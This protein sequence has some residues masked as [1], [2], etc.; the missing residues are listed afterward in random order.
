MAIG[1]SVMICIFEMHC[2]LTPMKLAL[3]L[4]GELWV[5]IEKLVIE[6]R[7]FY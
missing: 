1:S 3:E 6:M 4:N 7:F 2:G 5:K